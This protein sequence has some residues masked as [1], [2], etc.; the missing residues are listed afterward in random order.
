MNNDRD[1]SSYASNICNSNSYMLLCLYLPHAGLLPIHDSHVVDFV[2]LDAPLL[3]LIELLR[4]E[5]HERVV[6]CV[7]LMYVCIYVSE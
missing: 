6:W 1:M 7:S 5:A 4:N 3:S 2:L